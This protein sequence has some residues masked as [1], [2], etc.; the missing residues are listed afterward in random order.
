M[1]GSG[2]AT[3]PQACPPGETRTAPPGF[4]NALL[5]AANREIGGSKPDPV[6]DRNPVMEN[7]EFRRGE[8][9]NQ[10]SIH[11]F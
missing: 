1:Y 3:L 7:N 11:P 10:I 9:D 4:Q 8:I 5:P 6:Y 2:S